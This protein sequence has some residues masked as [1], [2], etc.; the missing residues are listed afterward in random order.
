M[1]D[2]TP[3]TSGSPTKRAEIEALRREVE[4]MIRRSGERIGL[5][6][7]LIALTRSGLPV[8]RIEPSGL[9]APFAAND[10]AADQRPGQKAG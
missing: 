5:I 10:S 3:D 1:A 7:D 9:P 2:D 6:D 4:E 8:L